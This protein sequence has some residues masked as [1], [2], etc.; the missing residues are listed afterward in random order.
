[1]LF[2]WVAYFS[3]QGPSSSPLKKKRAREQQFQGPCLRQ[4]E[5]QRQDTKKVYELIEGPLEL[6]LTDGAVCCSPVAEEDKDCL[7]RNTKFHHH[8]HEGDDECDV[9]K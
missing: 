4:T 7:K 9:C 1:M 5:R 6:Y 8:H 3:E 2:A